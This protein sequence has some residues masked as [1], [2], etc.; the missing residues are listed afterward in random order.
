MGRGNMAR[1]SADSREG[2]VRSALIGSFFG[3]ALE[4]YDFILFG[5][6]AGLVFSKLFFPSDDPL[7]GILL[8]FGVFAVGFV[9]R[10]FGGMIVAN[11]GDKVGRK[12]MLLLTLG[13]MGIV[14]AAIGILPT[15][16]QIGIAAPIILTL[17][18]FVQG[19]AYG[20]EWGGA[21]LVV[22]E[23]AP[24]GRRG[25]FGGFANGGSSLGTIFSGG[26][27]SLSLYATGDQFLS[28]GWRVP[29]LLGVAMVFVGFYVRTRI[30]ETPEFLALKGA[31]RARQL[32]IVDALR[33]HYREI[34]LT[35][36]ASTMTTATFYV[37]AIFM[38]SYGSRTLGMSM[39]TM[40]HGLMLQGV[41]VIGSSICFGALSDRIGRIPVVMAGAG[42]M[43]CYVFAFFW[44]VRSGD[45]ALMMLGLV[46]YGLLSGMTH[47][48][49]AALY[50]EIYDASI[51][52]SGATLGTQVGIV[53]GGGF[54]PMIA[55]ALLKQFDGATW[56]ISLYIVALSIVG[57][58]CFAALGVSQKRLAYA[59]AA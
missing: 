36:G 30:L 8:A 15:Y 45:E 47:G 54:S 33:R 35:I 41:A 46:G 12:P 2:A 13:S 42:V 58:A 25:F 43:A 39:H 11:Y 56:P 38:L 18:R 57:I 21:I 3:T 20:G 5:T 23:H 49:V 40:L 27:I 44:L 50:T 9:A 19:I 32:P 53:L 10:P 29:F 52:Y 34:L 16:A 4:T 6:T 24:K 28:W 48:P 22:I 14:T 7:N 59:A 37:M 31:G 26:V 1:S 17:L 51:R 55:T